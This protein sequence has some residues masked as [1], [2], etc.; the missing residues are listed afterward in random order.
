MSTRKG[1]VQFLD[2]ILTEVGDFMHSIMRRNKQKYSQVTDPPARR[3]F[4][5][6]PPSWSKTCRARG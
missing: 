3:S 2:D 5:P 1:N 4:S 6:Y